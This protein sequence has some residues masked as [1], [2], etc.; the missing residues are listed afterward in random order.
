MWEAGICFVAAQLVLAL[1]V[2]SFTGRKAGSP[3]KN[4]PGGARV[5][6]EFST[7][8]ALITGAGQFIFLYN[9][10]HSRFWGKTAPENP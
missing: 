4:F 3:L 2:W 1:F 10:M 6:V 7:I 5:M 9:L 8:A